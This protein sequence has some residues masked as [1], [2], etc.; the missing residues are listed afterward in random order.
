MNKIFCIGPNKT[1]TTS[2]HAAFEILGIRSAHFR[3]EHGNIKDI[4]EGNYL[5]ERPL[6]T[7]IDDFDAYSD[8]NRPRTNWYFKLFDT[9]YPG[10]KFI[11][12]TRDLESWMRSREHHVGRYSNL[13]ERRAQNPD[14]TWLNI[15]REAWTREWNELHHE[16][17]E[18]FADRN[19]DL[20]TLDV[21]AG[22]G[23]EKLCPFLGLPTPDLPFPSENAGNREQRGQTRSL[24]SQAKG[25]AERFL[26]FVER[27]H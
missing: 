27:P 23:W 11:L 18:Y 17:R 26:P 4:I 7:S 8:W 3:C 21:V 19:P 10:S 1:G 12:N 2:L 20:L 14:S 9:Q 13:A 25:F 15:D 22:D 6:L 16:V 5:S 24:S